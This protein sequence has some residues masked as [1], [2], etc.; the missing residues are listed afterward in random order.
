ME[1]MFN[2][3]GKRRVS[4]THHVFQMAQVVPQGYDKWNP[5][6]EREEIGCQPCGIY[7]L[8]MDQVEFPPVSGN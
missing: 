7:G 2:Q 1:H 5:M 8:S 4:L 6:P 3:I